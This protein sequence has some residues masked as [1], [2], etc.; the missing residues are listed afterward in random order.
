MLNLGFDW[1]FLLNQFVRSDF[2]ANKTVYQA[3]QLNKFVLS[4]LHKLTMAQLRPLLVSNVGSQGQ[5]QQMLANT[6][7]IWAAREELLETDW[8]EAIAG[9]YPKA[10]L[11]DD[12]W[13]EFL[14]QY[15]W[16]W[17]EMPEI[18][19]RMQRGDVRAFDADIDLSK[20]PSYYR[21]NFHHQTNGYLSDRSADLYDLQV[22]TLFGGLAEPMRRRVLRPLKD[23]LNSFPQTQ[24]QSLKV[25]DAP[26]GTG[27]A[28][29]ML[30]TALPKVKFSGL[31][32]S[33]NYL[34]KAGDRLREKFGTAPD[35]TQGAVENLPYA[36][37]EFHG[38]TSIFFF[39]ELPAPVR[40]QAIAEYFRVLKP[41]GTLVINDSIQ[42]GDRPTL[43][44]MMMGFPEMFHEPYY[45]NYLE[46]DLVERLAKAGFVNIRTEV[47]YFS[48]IWIAE[49]PLA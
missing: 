14:R 46:D 32:L 19:A 2:L 34:K 16:L 7:R 41:Q 37:G 20:Y 45:R 31:D 38:I 43:T 8:Q 39:H 5:Q 44:P 40:Q 36:D 22:E 28:L 23:A 3:L 29:A 25:L 42:A 11:F 6:S 49:K 15:P 21:Q 9:I 33:P 35:L 24:T 30:Q 17:L 1:S 10:L 12:P 27:S 47:H 4:L 13:V 18:W 48:K 26:C